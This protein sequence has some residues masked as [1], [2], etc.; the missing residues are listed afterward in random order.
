MLLAAAS[1]LR[2]EMPPSLALHVAE[3]VADNERNVQGLGTLL[4][5][6][7]ASFRGK[8]GLE[9]ESRVGALDNVLER[10]IRLAA[11]AVG[12]NVSISLTRGDAIGVRN[13]G[14]ALECVVAA[15]VIDLARAA[16]GRHV[17]A[18]R[19]APTIRLRAEAGRR[20]LAIEIESD[21]VQPIAGSWRAG[22]A[23]DLAARLDAGVSVMTNAVGYVV[24]L[25]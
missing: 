18:S 23:R 19:R 10:A 17:E 20:S 13:R 12:R 14:T 6:A 25:R 1:E 21:G 3:A 11:P 9:G 5:L 24:Q 2:A 15:L 8:E 4:S 22:L 7:D 16:D